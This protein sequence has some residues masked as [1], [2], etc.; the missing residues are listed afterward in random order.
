[1]S[2]DFAFNVTDHIVSQIFKSWGMVD[3]LMSELWLYRLHLNEPS[4][5][6]KE[7]PHFIAIPLLQCTHERLT[8]LGEGSWMWSLIFHLGGDMG[9]MLQN[10][11]INNFD[12]CIMFWLPR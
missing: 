10:S 2:D 7:K 9:V 1:M 11:V 12:G 6:S 3:T 5:A 4:F 8:C